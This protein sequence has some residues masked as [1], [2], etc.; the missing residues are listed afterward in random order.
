MDNEVSFQWLQRDQI[1]QTAY[2]NALNRDANSRV[3]SH[4][5][6]LDLLCNQQWGAIIINNYEFI[7][8]FPFLKK[9]GISLIYVPAFVQQLNPIG[10]QEK[11]EKLLRLNNNWGRFLSCIPPKIKYIEWQWNT[12]LSA[13]FNFSPA[14]QPSTLVLQK[15]GQQHELL[16]N[17]LFSFYQRSN[18][19]LPLGG[20]YTALEEKFRNN[21]KRNLKKAEAQQLQFETHIPIQDILNLAVFSLQLKAPIQQ[22]D[23]EKIIRAFEQFKQKGMAFSTGIRHPNGQL[24]AGAG[25]FEWNNRVY[26][27]IV[28]NHPNGKTLGASHALLA[29][30]MQWLIEEKARKNT[31]FDFEG[32][33]L[34]TL[35]FFYNSFGA[36]QETYWRYKI[37]RLPKWIRLLCSFHPRFEHLS[38]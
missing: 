4:P 34:P 20:S 5:L 6:Y 12:N 19:T 28:G 8:P 2:L 25:F 29:K 18:Y 26:Y 31:I 14:E 24:L 7:C 35:A 9:K 15:E 16:K 3:Y 21:V 32:S 11:L 23:Q 27:L 37:N 10:D 1:D 13:L 36:E 38:R 22:N 33:D 30:T 17:S